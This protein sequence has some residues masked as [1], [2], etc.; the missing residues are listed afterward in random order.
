[1][2]DKPLIDAADNVAV[3]TNE[4]TV[5]DLARILPATVSD[6]YMKLFGAELAQAIENARGTVDREKAVA[7]AALQ[8]APVTGQQ[9]GGP[10]TRMDSDQAAEYV[11][12][13]ALRG[14]NKPFLVDASLDADGLITQ[15]L[16][17]VSNAAG[18]YLMP[19]DFVAEI[20]KRAD[21]P[22][23][24][25]PRI[26]KRPTKFRSVT[27][28]TVTTYITPNAGVDAYAGSA[29][30]ATEISVSEP[31]FNDLTWTM[32]YMDAR[33]PVKLDLLQ[34]APQNIYQQLIELAGDGFNIYR[35]FYPIQGKGGTTFSQP[36][37]IMP[38][39][40]TLDGAYTSKIEY[41]SVG[42]LA[43]LSVTNI[44]DFV[45]TLGARYR[46]KAICLM[47]TQILYGVVRTLAEN[48][49]AAQ[50]LVGKLP[51]LEESEQ[52]NANHI[53]CGDFSRYIVYHNRLMELV[54]SV[55][56]QRYTMEIVVVEKWDGQP[57]IYDAFKIGKVTT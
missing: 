25:W 4:Q 9:R 38:L 35:E 53:I 52:V 6:E 13:T 51:P 5:K 46:G 29:T 50:F 27:Q 20:N 54:T 44:L 36:Q 18:G 45:A 34:D 47:P 10:L 41:T 21:E 11:R 15:A 17:G 26:T 43:S 31:V 22:A 1:M 2:P 40:G 49:R 39:A 30:T 19:D 57:T 12:C 55:V 24:V 33:M 7:I 32:R 42:V 28:A 48:V 8:P 37:G 14:F 16:T 23:V 3:V 56:A